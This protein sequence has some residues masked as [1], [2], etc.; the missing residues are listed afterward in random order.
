MNVHPSKTEVRFRH[1]S[2]VHDLVRDTIRGALMAERPVPTLAPLA[3]HILPRNLRRSPPPTCLI[4]NSA[5]ASKT[6][7]SPHR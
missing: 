7:A 1:G 3:R 4:P 2:L 5:S 6:W